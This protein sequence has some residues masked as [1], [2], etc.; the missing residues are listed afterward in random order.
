VV[1]W[2]VI[3]INASNIQYIRSRFQYRVIRIH[4]NALQSLP[5]PITS[6]TPLPSRVD[7]KGKSHRTR[8][9]IVDTDPL[10]CPTID[11]EIII[12]GQ[13]GAILAKETCVHLGQLGQ[14]IV[15]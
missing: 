9:A 13:F 15:R 4:N 8:L 14:A 11:I 2:C 12:P 10:P 7:W 6:F 1:S 3:M 5:P